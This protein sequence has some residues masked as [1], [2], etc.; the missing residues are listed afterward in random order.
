M[1]A[2]Q[3]SQHM[4]PQLAEIHDS[5]QFQDQMRECFQYMFD[6]YSTAEIAGIMNFWFNKKHITDKMMEH[7][8]DCA[9]YKKFVYRF[10]RIKSIKSVDCHGNIG[11]RMVFPT[12]L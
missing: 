2:P 10:N 12:Y 4:G 11:K 5:K 9:F 7:C 6:H 8:F 3:Y 1:T